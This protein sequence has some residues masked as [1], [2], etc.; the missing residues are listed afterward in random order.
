MN[1]SKWFTA[2]LSEA[3]A[4]K[5]PVLGIG[6]LFGEAFPRE[7][8][9][10]LGINI[11][12]VEPRQPTALYHSEE[13]E[14]V[15]LVLA[16]ECLAIVDGEEVALRQWDFLHCPRGTAHALIGAGDGPA[17][18][19]MVGARGEGRGIHYPVDETAARHGISVE[20]ETDDFQDA[21]EQVGLKPEFE[22]VPLPWPPG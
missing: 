6:Y 18:I 22:R 12:V 7:R 16:G 21:W 15:F 3:E 9:E 1:E 8:F 11:R 10:D 20:R 14:E 4:M 5:H 19:L 17:T 13:A 2:S